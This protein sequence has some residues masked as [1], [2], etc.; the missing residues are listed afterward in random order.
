MDDYLET[1]E[2]M[3][4]FQD[5]LYIATEGL[6]DPNAS[7]RF[8]LTQR[9]QDFIKGGF[10]KR[11]CLIQ[12]GA[13][14]GKS[15]FIHHLARQLW[16]EYESA[17]KKAIIPLFI[18]LSSL[19]SHNQDLIA[20]YF[21]ERDFNEDQI[22]L[23]RDTC[24]FVFI[25]D[26][27]DEIEKRDRNF[28]ADN[29]LGAW[30]A[31]V[32]I[33]SRPEY[34][35]SGYQSKF[36]PSR[37]P[38]LLQE[39]WIAPFSEQSI[40]TYITRYVDANPAGPSAEDYR[41]WVEKPEIAAL[42]STPFLLRMVMTVAPTL[43]Q[44]QLTRGVLYENFIGHWFV[45]EQARLDA[46][47]LSSTDREEFCRMYDTEFVLHVQYYCQ[48]F[49]LELY[50]H[51]VLEATYNHASPE[52]NSTWEQFLGNDKPRTRLSRCSSP[53]F[54][55]GH[56]YR[57]IHKSLRDYLVAQG[58]WQDQFFKDCTAKAYLNEFRI[59]DDP[60]IIDFVVDEAGRDEQLQRRLLDYVERSK[61]CIDIDCA[62]ANAITILVR[63]G[64]R[65][66]SHD[67]RGIRIPGADISSGWFDRAQ[68]QKAH[69][70]QVR[71]HDAWLRGADLTEAQMKG[72][73]F[74]ESPCFRFN[75]TKSTE[76]TSAYQ[77]TVFCFS[78]DGQLL[79]SAN[80]AGNYYVPTTVDL[81]SISEDE[82]LHVHTF[83]VEHPSYS[84]NFSRNGQLLIATVGSTIRMWS[85]PQFQLV[86]SFDEREHSQRYS[87]CIL[88]AKFSSDGQLLLSCSGWERSIRLWSVSQRK[89]DQNFDHSLFNLRGRERGTPMDADISPD[90]QIIASGNFGNVIHF[91]SVSRHERVY[92]FEGPI[93]SKE[94]KEESTRVLFSP[95]GQ[96]LAAISHKTI[97]L[98]PMSQ[99]PKSS[100]AHGS[101]KTD[102]GAYVRT[103]QQPIY[104]YTFDE[105]H[106]SV[107]YLKF[108]PD[109]QLLA[110]H[111]GIKQSIHIW[112]ISQKKK[113]YKLHMKG[114][115]G[116]FDF[117]PDGRSLVFGSKDI[118]R[119]WSVSGLQ[120][121]LT[122]PES[123]H[124]AWSFACL[125]F[126]SDGQLLVSGGM[127]CTIRLWSVS[128]G[129]VVHSFV[130]VDEP[131]RYWDAA[132]HS[133]KFSP[134]N[135]LLAYTVYDRKSPHITA[136]SIHLWSV[137]QRQY[138]HAFDVPMFPTNYGFSFLKLEYFSPDSQL[139][140]ISA[141][142][143]KTVHNN[144]VKERTGIIVFS[145][146]Q[147]QPVNSSILPPDTTEAALTQTM[148][149][150]DTKL[151]AMALSGGT[152][153]VWGVSQE[154]MVCTFE[155]LVQPAT[156]VDF[157]PDSQLLAS[158][159][160]NGT[161]CLWSVSQKQLVHTFE[162]HPNSYSDDNLHHF[163][164]VKF[165]PNGKLLV[166]SSEHTD[167]TNVRLWSVSQQ[168]C[169]AVF[170][171]PHGSK[172]IYWVETAEGDLLAICDHLSVSVG[173]WRIQKNI[174]S[175][176]GII[177]SLDITCLWSSMTSDTLYI[178]DMQVQGVT[179]LTYNDSRLLEQLGATGELALVEKSSKH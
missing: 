14:S 38:H 27:Y 2:Y 118:L 30:K 28:Y 8:D 161:V 53:L 69:M 64:M 166:S 109:S 42:I 15:T 152:I 126:S 115:S 157:S 120:T 101:L 173:V 61:T 150:P 80:T 143:K 130:H 17:P 99:P 155:S 92:V 35:A 1:L 66:T 114:G 128:Q 147:R 132:L 55:T 156:S 82:L 113:I 83:P 158:G 176:S 160:G 71:L 75:P 6:A 129:Q 78:P 106:S 103:G 4:A 145:V 151:L 174:C 116:N 86:H 46:I 110:A 104:V 11:V 54:R 76:S 29:K 135:Q 153:C 159:H 58:L 57:F 172:N 13:G 18:S 91:W 77:L 100:L 56:S 20:A 112:S 96:L 138:I 124:D 108:S 117:S 44:G 49:A 70:S 52:R 72:V 107:S 65:F 3:D 89:L 149:S 22:K 41:I 133:V 74:G 45:T 25:L 12:G 175:A 125:D 122:P 81:W 24:H 139:L 63:T 19:Q 47:E 85:I 121:D 31:K 67:L 179:G 60:G 5:N 177:E 62:A 105:K 21:K 94:S 33:T 178:N 140:T 84:L 26:G 102:T 136:Y 170:N 146:L 98:W 32:V 16:S 164:T 123:N 39:Y 163:N 111:D 131:R 7:E 51:Q 43:G 127:D 36:Y 50:R 165:S 167:G 88:A 119:L 144:D 93:Y 34:L 171:N 87:S 162:S 40:K 59:V 148:S 90:G 79:A 142:I 9:L 10:R 37:Q 23:A 154:Q 68:L 134:N 137:S 73:E 169:L 48:N 97:S 168:K 95:D 141:N